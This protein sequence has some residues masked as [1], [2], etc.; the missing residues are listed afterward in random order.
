MPMLR[1]MIAE[2]LEPLQAELAE[3]RGHLGQKKERSRFEVS[4]SHIPPEVEE[5]LWARLREDLSV[6]ALQQTREQTEKLLGAAQSA[7]ELKVTEAQDDYRQWVREQLSPL[8][9]RME[10]I[11]RQTADELRSSL[12]AAS[13]QFDQRAAVA[14]AGLAQKSEELLDSLL[15]RLEEQRE[16]HR[17]Q[18]EAVQVA[19]AAEASR[20]QT[21]LAEL[22]RRMAEIDEAAHNL[23]SGVNA[24]LMKMSNEMIAAGRAELQSA[25]D[26]MFQNLAAR[27]AK[28]LGQHL[29]HATARLHKLQNEIEVAVSESLRSSI[30]ETMQRFKQAMDDSAQR[31]IEGWRVALAKN[32][33]S[34]ARILGEPF[35]TTQEG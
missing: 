21:Q 11:S 26:A 1:A 6:Q 24:R 31:S 27:N 3:I 33:T 23:E 7:I 17:R 9:Q 35:R 22:G 10:T 32:L 5:K 4:L 28:D 8:E 20:L 19:A 30:S 18:L 29:E 25:A 2:Q 13:E 16:A 34:V 14:G 12:R 15:H